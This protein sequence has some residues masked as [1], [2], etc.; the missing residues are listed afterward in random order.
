VLSA[1]EIGRLMQVFVDGAHRGQHIGATMV[2]RAL[3]ICA[4][5]LHKHIF[6]SVTPEQT[7]AANLYASFGFRELATFTA[8]EATM[9]PQMNTDEHR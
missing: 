4:R 6:A 1:G 3:E 9:R 7:A 2:A 5:S 8:Y